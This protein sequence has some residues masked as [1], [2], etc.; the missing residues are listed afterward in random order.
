MRSAV[1]AVIVLALGGGAGCETAA[2]TQADQRSAAMAM[3]AAPPA[4]KL[5][6]Q[7]LEPGRGD[8]EGGTYVRIV[9]TGFLHDARGNAASSPPSLKVYFGSRQGEVVRLVSDT[10]LIV[11]APGGKA[12]DVA[13]VLVLFDG[14]GEMKLPHAFTF[15]DRGSVETTTT[16]IGMGRPPQIATSSDLPAAC[17]AYKASIYKLSKC[18]KMPQEARDAM[19]RAF[20]QA[21]AG[22]A[23]LPPEAKSALATACAAGDGAVRQSLQACQ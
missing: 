4:A 18:P 9:G 16:T 15:V 11:Q 21:A 6:L 10:E 22:W 2:S 1:L 12:D 13:D 14:R 7:S 20:D 3:P 17:E 19:K 5:A 23:N 8:A